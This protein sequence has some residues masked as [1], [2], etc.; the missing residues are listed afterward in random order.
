MYS[1]GINRAARYEVT[2]VENVYDWPVRKDLINQGLAKLG[3]ALASGTYPI[4]TD[5]AWL[6][7]LFLWD[8]I[9]MRGFGS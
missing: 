1:D 3:S 4:A 7:L 5:S 8:S 9:I 2:L 6:R